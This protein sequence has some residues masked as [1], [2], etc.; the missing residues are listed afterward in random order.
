MLN[1]KP[2]RNIAPDD[3]TYGCRSAIQKSIR[4]GDLDLCKTAFDELWRH[5]EQRTWLKWRLPILVEEEAW[6]MAGELSKMTTDPTE[7]ELRRFIYRLCICTKNKDSHGLLILGYNHG[8]S[9]YPLP[10]SLEG[11]TEYETI[12]WL[13]SRTKG[14]DP[15]VLVPFVIDRCRKVA[16]RELSEY[17]LAGIQTLADRVPKGGML[18]D[19]HGCLTSML[20]IAHRGINEKEIVSDVDQRASEWRDEHKRKPRKVDLPWY[21]FDMHTQAGKIALGIFMRNH[22]KKK[23][24]DLDKDRFSK[25]WFSFSSGKMSRKITNYI[26]VTSAP[27]CFD[28]MWWIPFLRGYSRLAGHTAKEV[29]NVWRLSME[30]EIESCVNWILNKRASK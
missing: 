2:I 29:S 22:A 14:N 25:I 11:H 3:Y 21:V 9:A 6:H 16:G 24:P 1:N 17:E 8:Q 26:D 7:K 5:K 18:G 19:R 28:T 23:W 12:K 10:P 15:A 4:R 27:T 20:L 30:S 13:T